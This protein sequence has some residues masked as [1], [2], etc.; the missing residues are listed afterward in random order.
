MSHAL[1]VLEAVRMPDG[2]AAANGESQDDDGDTVTVNCVHCL[3][4]VAVGEDGGSCCR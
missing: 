4:T 2:V 3:T 1:K